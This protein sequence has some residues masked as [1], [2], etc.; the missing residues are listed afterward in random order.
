MPP[1][2]YRSPPSGVVFQPPAVIVV[3]FAGKKPSW[4][5]RAWRWQREDGDWRAT[6]GG[7][8]GTGRWRRMRNINIICS[9]CWRQFWQ[10]WLHFLAPS[11]AFSIQHSASSCQCH[12]PQPQSC[13]CTRCFYLYKDDGLLFTSSTP[14]LTCYSADHSRHSMYSML[15]TSIST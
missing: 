2:R 15:H 13:P 6:G 12:M 3:V 11:S 4:E 1:S 7:G 10:P 9:G 14:A 5:L 8:T